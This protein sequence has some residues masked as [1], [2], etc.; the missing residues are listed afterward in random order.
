M[1]RLDL[2]AELAATL[3][4]VDA[5]LEQLT[6]PEF[7]RGLELWPDSIT[8]AMEELLA[9]RIV[10][11][12]AVELMPEHAKALR[13]LYSTERTQAHWDPP[14]Y[15]IL[16]LLP[17]TLERM[18]ATAEILRRERILNRELDHAMWLRVDN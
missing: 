13:D 16:P 4:V 15:P 1:S 6:S 18:D 5:D 8:E 9:L 10:M 3:D 11:R 14:R 2:V 7:A 12:R 17:E